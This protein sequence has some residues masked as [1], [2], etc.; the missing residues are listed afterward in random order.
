M[1]NSSLSDRV[2]HPQLIIIRFYKTR[3]E[4]ILFLQS[5]FEDGVLVLDRDPNDVKIVFFS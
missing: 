4:T 2:A 1:N 5:S 3:L